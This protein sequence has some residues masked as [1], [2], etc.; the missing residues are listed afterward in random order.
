MIN[1][2]HSIKHRFRNT[3]FGCRAVIDIYVVISISMTAE[4]KPQKMS[5]TNYICDRAAV[6]VSASSQEFRNYGVLEK[7]LNL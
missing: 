4:T 5:V 6:T 2:I 1:P 7:L 3:P